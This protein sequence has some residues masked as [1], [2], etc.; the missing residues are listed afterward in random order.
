MSYNMGIQVAIAQAVLKHTMDG[1]HRDV[2]E[3]SN[4]LL[5]LKLQRKLKKGCLQ[6]RRGCIR[7]TLAY[8]LYHFFVNPQK[9]FSPY[10]LVGTFNKLKP[11]LPLEILMT[12][13]LW[14]WSL[15]TF[16]YLNTTF[17]NIS[18]KWKSFFKVKAWVS[19]PRHSGPKGSA[20]GPPKWCRSTYVM[21]NAITHTKKLCIAGSPTDGRISHYLLWLSSSIAKKFDTRL[22]FVLAGFNLSLEPKSGSLWA[23]TGP[24]AGVQDEPWRMDAMRGWLQAQ[25]TAPCHQELKVWADSQ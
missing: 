11:S 21:K 8:H 1:A 9:G 16:V 22:Q 25:L 19:S 6:I 4:C 7:D 18:L 12:F 10:C 2:Q 13:S 24:Q 23:L 3:F 20:A 15:P 5:L 17:A 14:E